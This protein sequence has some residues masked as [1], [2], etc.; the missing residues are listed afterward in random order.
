MIIIFGHDSIQ[1]IDLKIKENPCIAGDI[2]KSTMIEIQAK[3][4]TWSVVDDSWQLSRYNLH[5]YNLNEVDRLGDGGNP[6]YLEHHGSVF[7]RLN[8]TCHG[9]IKGLVIRATASTGRHQPTNMKQDDGENWART[10]YTLGRDQVNAVPIACRMAIHPC[11]VAK[12]LVA[13]CKTDNSGGYLVINCVGDCA[14]CPLCY[15]VLC[16]SQMV[17]RRWSQVLLWLGRM[18]SMLSRPCHF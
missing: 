12:R 17:E 5:N 10:N 7:D 16:T 6:H 13:Q 2:Y 1:N 15:H 18:L 8:V 14:Q 9:H 11:L 4:V 3:T